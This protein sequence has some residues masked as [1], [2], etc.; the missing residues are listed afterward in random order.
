MRPEKC[1]LSGNILGWVP[2]L[3]VASKV[4][5]YVAVAEGLGGAVV[6]VVTVEAVIGESAPL[7]LSNK[8]NTGISR[9]HRRFWL[10]QASVSEDCHN[11]TRPFWA[12]VTSGV[13]RR[14]VFHQFSLRHQ[15]L[16]LLLLHYYPE[17]FQDALGAFAMTR[18]RASRESI[19]TR[20]RSSMQPSGI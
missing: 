16:E 9:I 20:I 17:K 18:P 14:K 7:H 13:S 19:S 3:Q 10:I 5:R 15:Q 2:R 6:V 11:K 12:E 1:G 4:T 8:M